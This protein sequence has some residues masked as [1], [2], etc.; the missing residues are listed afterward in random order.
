MNIQPSNQKMPAITISAA[1]MAGDAA[2]AGT[3]ELMAVRTTLTIS[4]VIPE[5]RY[6]LKCSFKIHLA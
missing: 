5:I 6:T 1:W 3:I 2:D 4:D